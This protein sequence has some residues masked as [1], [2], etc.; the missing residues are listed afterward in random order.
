MLLKEIL[1]Q[2]TQSNNYI[3]INPQTGLLHEETMGNSLPN[4]DKFY[5]KVQM[6]F[7]SITNKEISSIPDQLHNNY[8]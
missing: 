6:L 7:D 8:I 5:A 3:N 2:T 1:Q 4:A